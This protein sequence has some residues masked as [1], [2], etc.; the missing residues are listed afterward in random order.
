MKHYVGIDVGGTRL[1]AG[2]VNERHEVVRDVVAWVEDGPRM[3]GDA[4]AQRLAS[5]IVEVCGGV[6]PVLVGLGVPGVIDR[7][8]GI[9]CRSPN[10]PTWRDVPIQRRVSDL[11]GH[12]VVLDNDA[13][14]VI[15]GEALRGAGAGRGDL[16]GLTLGTGV[17]GGIILGGALWRGARGMAGELGHLCVDPNGPPCGCGSRGCLEMYPSVNG[18]RLQVRAHGPIDGVDAEAADLPEQLATRARAGD[19]K[20]IACF[21]AVAGPFGRGLGS[22]LNIFDVKTVVLAGGVA[23]TWD[24]MAET[25]LAALRGACFP[26]IAAGVDVR[27][28][29]LGERAGIL[30]AAFQWQF[31]P[32]H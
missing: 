31:Q 9:V 8:R 32:H 25:A 27:V 13:N 19:P 4:L 10:F 15:A 3:D 30:G 7:E 11:S 16:I 24:L 1:K 12:A 20:A 14:C 5:L 29:T 28:G 18:L 23:H 21:Q 26:E 22:L 2:L 17:G 6:R